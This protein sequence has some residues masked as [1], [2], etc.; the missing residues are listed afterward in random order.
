MKFEYLLFN[1][2]II[3]G[4]LIFGS[5]KQFY[6]FDRWRNVLISAIIIAIPFIV[7]DSIVTGE[8]WTFNSQYTLDFR[9]AHL[10]IEEWMFFLTVPVACLFTWEMILRRSRGSRTDI[11][12][13]IRYSAFVLP[14]LGIGL[15]SLGKQYTG[16]VFIFIAIAIYMDYY[17]K[18]DLVLQKRFYVYVALVIIFTLVFNGYLT[19]R[20]VVLYE[21]SYQ[22]DFRIFT[23][24]IEDF[25]YGLALVFM[26]TILYERFKVSRLLGISE[27]GLG[28]K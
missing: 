22:L 28:K 14:I 6:F 3:A 19:W 12:K 15:F 18:T 16:L 20:P 24:P 1:M 11:G 23:I 8:H 4:P 21:V 17:F 13:M 10:P 7:W 25:G 5:L 27:Y 2:I 9:L 26:C